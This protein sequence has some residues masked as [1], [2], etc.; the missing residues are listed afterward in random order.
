MGAMLESETTAATTGAQGVRKWNVMSNM[1]FLSMSVGKYLQNNLDFAK[2]IR[3]P[4]VFGTNYFLRKDGKHLNGMLDKA[5][6]A[7]WIELRAH[8][9]VE[10]LDAGYGL[11]PKYEDLKRLF[12][13]VLK[14][15][16][17]E[18]D[19]QQQFKIRIPELLAKLDRMEKIY[20]TV[21]GTPQAMQREMA[22]QR[23]RLE[24]LKAAKGEYVS[25]MDL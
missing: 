20:A 11:I 2:E 4:K 12:Q 16:Y 1:D 25:P 8:D 17:T 21:Q 23:K 14:R 5:V 13:Q 9:E 18:Q 6:W 22:D 24:A 19:Y 10:A 3:R 15:D 7:K